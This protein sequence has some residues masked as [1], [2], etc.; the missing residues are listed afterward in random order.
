M[1]RRKRLIVMFMNLLVYPA[2]SDVISV[3]LH[4][5]I[6]VPNVSSIQKTVPDDILQFLGSTVGKTSLSEL[7]KRLKDTRILEDSG[8]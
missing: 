6:M 2:Y 1:L 7:S 5:G 4:D 8:I 3:E